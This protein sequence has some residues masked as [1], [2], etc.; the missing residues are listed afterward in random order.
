MSLYGADYRELARDARLEL[1]ALVNDTLALAR[2]LNERI[3]VA[4][5]TS[6]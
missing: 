1:G 2:L 4:E 3:D 5:Q 6:E